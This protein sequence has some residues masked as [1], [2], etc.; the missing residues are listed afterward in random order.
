MVLPLPLWMPQHGSKL[1]LLENTGAGM[2]GDPQVPLTLSLLTLIGSNYTSC[3]W[4]VYHTGQKWV[5]RTTQASG[6]RV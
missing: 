4:V 3:Q 1:G 2:G 6:G 5:S